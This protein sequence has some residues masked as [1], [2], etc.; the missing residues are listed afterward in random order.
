MTRRSPCSRMSPPYGDT[1]QLRR[2]TNEDAPSCKRSCKQS[3]RSGQ[4]TFPRA[5]A[6]AIDR[7]TSWRPLARAQYGPS[8]EAPARA[9][10]SSF[11]WTTRE[12]AWSQNGHARASACEPACLEA[13]MSVVSPRGCPRQRSRPRPSPSGTTSSVCSWRPVFMPSMRM[14]GPAFLRQCQAFSHTTPQNPGN[15]FA[16]VSNPDGAS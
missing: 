13:S 15:R 11:Q 5:V 16:L 1:G 6:P 8:H 3:H 4:L 12:L 7:S 14:A 2:R 10:V 9:G